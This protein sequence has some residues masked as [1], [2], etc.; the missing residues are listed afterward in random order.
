MPPLKFVKMNVSLSLPGP[1][2]IELPLLEEVKAIVHG[3]KPTEPDLPVSP[4][5]VPTHVVAVA[6]ADCVCVKVVVMSLFVRRGVDVVTVIVLVE[7]PVAT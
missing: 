3:P 7:W 2:I 4:V 1:S 5:F 6:T